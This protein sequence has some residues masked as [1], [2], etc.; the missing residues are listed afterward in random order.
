MR[1]SNQSYPYL[2]DMS[3]ALHI[4]VSIIELIVIT[5][6]GIFIILYGI[7]ALCMPSSKHAGIL[8]VIFDLKN[9]SQ[10][11][12]TDIQT[13]SDSI[14]NY[15]IGT[16]YFCTG[17][18]SSISCND[19]PL[20]FSELLSQELTVSTITPIRSTSTLSQSLKYV[21]QGTMEIPLI[22]GIISTVFLVALFHYSFWKGE[23]IFEYMSWGLPLEL[24]LSSIGNLI[25]VIFFM[26]PT[27]ILS[28][29]YSTARNLPPGITAKKGRFFH[30]C[31]ILGCSAVAIAI[32][33][34]SRSLRKYIL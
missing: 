30:D 28:V 24:V 15:T 13:A 11:H 16:K 7:V 31:I 2:L 18:A 9:S 20:R 5:S 26:L 8:T 4:W 14:K 17:Y 33:V 19:L 22:I 6:S 34:V 29:L 10:Q 21:S 27:I 12:P 3:I 23:A 1:L 25:C 32:C